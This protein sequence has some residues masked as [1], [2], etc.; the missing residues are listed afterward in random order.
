ML[1]RISHRA[2]LGAILVFMFLPFYSIA[3]DA[4]RSPAGGEAVDLRGVKHGYYYAV[5]ANDCFDNEFLK[6]GMT[7]E[8]WFYPARQT[9]RGEVWRLISKSSLYWLNMRHFYL[10]P[11][12]NN[13]QEA[14]SMQLSKD[15]SAWGFWDLTGEGDYDPEWHHIVYQGRLFGSTF[16]RRVYQDAVLIQVGSSSNSRRVYDTD[17]P[18]QVGGAP[19]SAKAGVHDGSM[20]YSVA[21]VTTFDGLIDEMRISGVER[22]KQSVMGG[23]IDVKNRFQADEHTVA[24]WHFDEGPRSLVYQDDSGNGHSLFAAGELGVDPRNS[25]PIL[26]GMIKSQAK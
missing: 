25:T 22:Y 24:L 13:G 1:D 21:D 8:F 20:Q 17:T 12:N 10:A 7:I 23:K 16:H 3:K 26:W 15:G 14:E 11:E 19:E 4:L 6:N 18:L 9:E 5:D 2:I